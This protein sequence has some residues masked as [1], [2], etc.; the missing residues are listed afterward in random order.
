MQYKNEK[1]E[2]NREGFLVSKTYR[3]CTN[4]RKVYKKTSK[5]VTLCPSCNTERVKSLSIETKMRNRAQQRAKK[6]NIEFNL[7]KKDIKV[8]TKCPILEIP[9][10]IH[11]GTSGGR[12]HSPSLDRIDP[13]KGY[14]KDNVWVI[15]QL[16]NIMKSN[17]DKEMLIIFANWVLKYY[18]S[19]NKK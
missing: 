3:Q 7:E 8:P 5:T 11:N 12:N 4:C 19:P 2:P 16:A 10:V 1:L 15:S 17:A 13:N 14:T 6:N 18:D 9:L